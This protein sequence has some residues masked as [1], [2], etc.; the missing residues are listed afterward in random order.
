MLPF[1]YLTAFTCCL[2]LETLPALSGKNSGILLIYRICNIK[3]TS[4]YSFTVNNQRKSQQLHSVSNTRT[5][6][7]VRA[8]AHTHICVTNI[9]WFTLVSTVAFDAQAKKIYYN[10]YCALQLLCIWQLK[11]LKALLSSNIYRPAA[12]LYNSTGKIS[13]WTPGQVAPTVSHYRVIYH[14]H[15]KH[16]L[17]WAMRKNEVSR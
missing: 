6:T 10:C 14:F 9:V 3:W 11:Y 15:S 8:H 13:S 4:E 17:E 1:A 7:Y 12:T 5:H 2:L 16:I